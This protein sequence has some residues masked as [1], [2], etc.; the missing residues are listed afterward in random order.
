MEKAKWLGAKCKF[1]SLLQSWMCVD[2]HLHCPGRAQS[3]GNR[4]WH[5][6]EAQK[7]DVAV[8]Y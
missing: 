2:L 1:V 4:S 7:C 6:L 3:T 8:S 5:M